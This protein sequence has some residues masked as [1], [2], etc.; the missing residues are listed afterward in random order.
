MGA[1]A[2]RSLH[3]WTSMSTGWAGMMMAAEGVSLPTSASTRGGNQIPPCMRPLRAPLRGAPCTGPPRR[4]CVVGPGWLPVRLPGCSRQPARTVTLWTSTHSEFYSR[5][6]LRAFTPGNGPVTGPVAGRKNAKNAQDAD[7]V[8]SGTVNV[9]DLSRFARW[10]NRTSWDLPGT[11]PRFLEGRKLRVRIHLTR[12]TNRTLAH[13]LSLAAGISKNAA[14]GRTGHM[15]QLGR[16]GHMRLLWRKWGK[17]GGAVTRSPH[18]SLATR[19]ST[20]T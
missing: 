9:P 19:P 13:S 8:K 10:A 7:P 17:R 20:C 11:N 1:A 12:G 6:V 16:H 18:A 5:C 2:H 15:G 3:R 4:R 14:A